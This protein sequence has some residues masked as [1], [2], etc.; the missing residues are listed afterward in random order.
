MIYRRLAIAAAIGFL[1]AV[2]VYYNGYYLLNLSLDAEGIRLLG[3][4]SLQAFGM[5]VL[6]AGSTYG[7]LRYTLVCPFALTV[8]FTAYSLYD[9]V[10]PAMEGF[11][12]LYLGVWFVFVVVVALVATLEYGVRSGLAIY[13]PEPL[14]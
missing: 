1:N 4:K 5:F 9:H 3:Y 14:L 11:T 7:L 13:P 2:I 12:P 8:L 6:G 10:S